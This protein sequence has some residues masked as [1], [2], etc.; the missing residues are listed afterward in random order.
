[1]GLASD[2]IT[3][4]N[5]QSVGSDDFPPTHYQH[6]P[7]QTPER[8]AW[9]MISDSSVSGESLTGEPPDTFVVDLEI[10]TNSTLELEAIAAVISAMN[11]YS[12]DLGAGSVQLVEIGNQSDDYVPLVDREDLPAYF[13]SYRLTLIGYEE[14]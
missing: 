7:K 10:Y 1:M 9:F 14:S 6:L 3:W 12:G 4:L 5:S 11:D 8:F 13:S 2:L